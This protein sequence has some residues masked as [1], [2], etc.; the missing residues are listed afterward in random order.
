MA[1][2]S[3]SEVMAV[4]TELPDT[5]DE[6]V[7]TAERR[8]EL[9]CR[10]CGDTVERRYLDN[11]VCVGCRN[12]LVTDGGQ[13]RDDDDLDKIAGEPGVPDGEG[14]PLDEAGSVTTADGSNSLV[15]QERVK[16]IIA[17]FD[18]LSENG[19]PTAEVVGLALQDHR[20]HTLD[21]LEAIETLIESG[22]IYGPTNSTL[23]VT[24]LPASM[25]GDVETGKLGLTYR[26]P[27]TK[28]GGSDD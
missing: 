10:E 12:K 19:A 2:V 27:G 3:V 18:D 11:R 16:E 14:T 25:V 4:S 8:D 21:V 9:P 7:E 15:A 23:K 24:D 5:I 17:R 22:E 28:R 6:L 26:G 1:T 13:D 20:L